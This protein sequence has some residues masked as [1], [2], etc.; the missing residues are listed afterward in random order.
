MLNPEKERAPVILNFPLI[1]NESII[2]N[3]FM[4]CIIILFINLYFQRK[5]QT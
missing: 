1:K 4:K 5:N 3:F 2:L